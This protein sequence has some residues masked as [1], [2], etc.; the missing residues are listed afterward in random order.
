MSVSFGS[1]TGVERV[2]VALVFEPVKVA[3]PTCVV[4]SQIETCTRSDAEL[5]AVLVSVRPMRFKFTASFVARKRITPTVLPVVPAAAIAYE[6][7]EGEVEAV[8]V[9]MPTVC[10]VPVVVVPVAVTEVL[11]YTGNGHC[12]NLSICHVPSE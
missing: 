5:D 11:S 2:D 10:T 4:P 9:L 1:V 8:S 7:L 3:V 6:G 12:I